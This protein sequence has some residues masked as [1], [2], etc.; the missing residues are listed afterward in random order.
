MRLRVLKADL[1][2]NE[3][4]TR[5]PFRFGV[6]TMTWAPIVLAQVDVEDEQGTRSSGAASDLLVPRWFDKDPSK[7]PREN[8][9]DLLEATRHS[10]E[11]M[12]SLR[13]STLPVFELWRRTHRDCSRRRRHAG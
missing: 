13:S 8:V 1:W 5:L 4:A 10:V 2:M 9:R 6:T 12:M 11:A 3:A 7:S